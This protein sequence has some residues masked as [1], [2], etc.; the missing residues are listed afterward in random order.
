MGGQLNIKPVILSFY[1][2]LSFLADQYSDST[3]ALSKHGV[4]Y[5]KHT[6]FEVQHT[7]LKGAP[8]DSSV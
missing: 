4:S 7:V 2:E 8:S 5:A 3:L 1:A 6:L